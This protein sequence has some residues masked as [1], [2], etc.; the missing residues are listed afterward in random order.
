MFTYAFCITLFCSVAKISLDVPLYAISSLTIRGSA[1]VNCQPANLYCAISE[2]VSAVA[3]S[4]VSGDW[5]QSRWGS[6]SDG[7]FLQEPSQAESA[8]IGR[9]EI[10]ITILYFVI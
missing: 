5:N 2:R 3:V 8:V 9:V 6:R 1:T 10:H 4:G 7:K